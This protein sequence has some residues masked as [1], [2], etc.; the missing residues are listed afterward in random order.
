[1]H[2]ADLFDRRRAQR[3]PQ[4][5][6]AA[7][8]EA[9]LAEAPVD[10]LPVGVADLL[11]HPHPRPLRRGGRHHRRLREPLLKVFQDDRRIEDGRALVG[12]RGDFEAR[13]ELGEAGIVAARADRVGGDE[14][15]RQALFAQQDA[16]LLGVGRQ[17]MFV[18]QD[19]AGHRIS[20]LRMTITL[21]I[22]PLRPPAPGRGVGG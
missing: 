21:I 16:H 20:A 9:D 12:E 6:A 13:V 14:L 5:L 10:R 18:Q 1:M 15:E 8:K 3:R 11:D 19:R 22:A 17:R 4:T 7:A 2:M